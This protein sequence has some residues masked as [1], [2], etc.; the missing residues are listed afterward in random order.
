MVVFTSVKRTLYLHVLPLSNPLIIHQ[1]YVLD[2]L[3]SLYFIVD[4]KTILLLITF[5]E[6]N[7]LNIQ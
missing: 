3:N 4:I 1:I 7:I 6:N 5:L 2:S